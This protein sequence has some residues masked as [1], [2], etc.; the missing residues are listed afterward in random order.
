VDSKLVVIDSGHSPHTSNP[1]A[2]AAQLVPLLDPAFRATG[3]SSPTESASARG[4][5]DK[6]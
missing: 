6:A 5:D 4:E 2:V 3:S 1:E